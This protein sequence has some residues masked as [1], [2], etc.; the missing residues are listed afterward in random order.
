MGID[1]LAAF[2]LRGFAWVC[3]SA[4]FDRLFGGFRRGAMLA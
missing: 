1:K 3:L 2:C 4:T